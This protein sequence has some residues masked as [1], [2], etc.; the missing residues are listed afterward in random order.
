MISCVYEYNFTGLADRRQDS[1]LVG[2]MYHPLA[3]RLRS[4]RNIHQLHRSAMAPE[5]PP[6]SP[7]S[8]PTRSSPS[9]R[10]TTIIV[11]VISYIESVKVPWSKSKSKSK[12]DNDN[13]NDGGQQHND[14]VYVISG[15]ER[16]LYGT[17]AAADVV[18]ICGIHPPRY[19]FY[20]VSGFVCDILQFTI[21]ALLFLQLQDASACWA[22]SFMIS[23]V[24]RHTTHRYLVFGDY[25]GGYWK[26]LG[27]MYAGYSIIIA[28]ST[29]FN[30]AMTH[31]VHVPHMVGFVV[32]LLWTGIV[33][34]FILK[35][36]WSFGGPASNNE[37]K[38]DAEATTGGSN[39]AQQELTLLATTNT[40]NR[41]MV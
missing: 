23:I 18:T 30:I 37:K 26:S 36:L 29:L 19:L 21:D 28:L 40:K 10:R 27:R 22:I 41:D 38:T 33:N 20:M 7:P 6:R 9:S 3:K 1:L 31:Y 34:Y 17:Q 16:V 14:V 5:V 11:R 39:A 32:T 35:K 24:F 8:P 2:T 25:V 12:N 4:R 13:N 15:M